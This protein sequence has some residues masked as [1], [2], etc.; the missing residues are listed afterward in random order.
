M[1]LMASLDLEVAYIT[2]CRICIEDI[3]LSLRGGHVKTLA[4]HNG[5]SI[6]HKPGDQVTYLYKI[7]PDVVSDGTPVFGKDG[8]VLN[9]DIKAK[10]LVSEDCTPSVTIS[11]QTA[12]DFTAEQNASLVKAAHRLSNPTTQSLKPPNPDALPPHDSEIQQGEDALG[13]V[14]NVTLTISGPARVHV[15]DMFHWGVFI[16]N[17]SDKTRKLAV[18]VVPKRKREYD[19]HQSQLSTS[20]AGGYRGDG[21]DLLASAVVDENVIYAKQKNARLDAAELMCLTTDV[22]V[23]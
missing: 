8:H 9:M 10:V 13:K 3:R 19:R 22:R 15:G 7:T 20:S 5:A 11:W 4:D 6:V 1:S 18:L 2:G 21:K 12:V 17:R 23:G 16:V 14:I